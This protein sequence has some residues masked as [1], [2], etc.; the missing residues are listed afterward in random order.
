MN[1]IDLSFFFFLR[2]CANRWPG[3]DSFMDMLT[4]N[5]VLKAAPVLVIV[6]AATREP[7]IDAR[8]SSRRSWPAAVRPFSRSG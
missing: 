8:T 4:G 7:P 6:W 5:E 1:S 3:L 2:A